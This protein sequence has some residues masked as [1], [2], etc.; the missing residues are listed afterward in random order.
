MQFLF[1]N[2]K[3]AFIFC[4]QN[5]IG[6]FFQNNLRFNA[7]LSSV[8]PRHF[9]QKSVSNENYN[10][11]NEVNDDAILDLTRQLKRRT[12][13]NLLQDTIIN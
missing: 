2:N 8:L 10:K 13:S 5:K 4:R 1:N 7:M 9:T 6:N 3:D 11:H 12:K